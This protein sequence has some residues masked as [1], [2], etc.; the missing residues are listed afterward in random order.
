MRKSDLVQ[1]CSVLAAAAPMLTSSAQ[2]AVCGP[3]GFGHY[4]HMKDWIEHFRAAARALPVSHVWRG[5]GSALFVELGRLTPSTRRDGTTGQAEGE[6]GLM[7][8]WG[9]RIED[10]DSIVCGSWSDEELWKPN[11]A[12]LVGQQVD[13]VSTFARLPEIQLS[14]SGGFH[15][16]SFM[17]AEGAPQWTLFDRRGPKIITLGCRSGI[18]IEWE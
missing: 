12:R 4:Q 2:S 6:I 15:I 18:V 8:E 3:V 16:V 17:T 11:F 9:W 7:V 1:R 14:L 13:D 10:Q 5:H